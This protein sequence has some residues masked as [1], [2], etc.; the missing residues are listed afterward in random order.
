[1][2]A[3]ANMMDLFAHKF[4][5]LRRSGFSLA[6]IF[7]GAVDGFLVGHENSPPQIK[8]LPNSNS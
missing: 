8:I 2:L 5:R 3:F 4:S 1:M 7:A 6:R